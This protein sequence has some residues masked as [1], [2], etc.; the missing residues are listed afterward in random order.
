LFYLGELALAHTH[1]EQAVALYDRQQHNSYVARY[2][3]DPAVV[4]LSYAALALWLLGYPDRARERSSAALTLAQE[5]SH[6]YSQALALNFAATL[7][8]YR[9][10]GSIVQ[11]W[12]ET[13]IALSNEQGFL[14]RVAWGTLLHG[15]ALTEQGYGEQGL[16]QMR[17]GLAFWQAT[18]A[19]LVRPHCL[20]MLAE[21]YGKVG[22]AEEG[23]SVL[24][25][26]LAAVDKTGECAHEAELYRLKGELTLHRASIQNPQSA[27][28]HLQSEAE[29]CFQK[30]IEIARK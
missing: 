28:C 22:Q 12:A 5:L 9:R 4:C 15:W 23:L 11:E 1:L 20:A 3:Q 27:F 26:A 13:V 29:A 6:P 8:Q 7:H 14:F 25:E 21:T 30:A 2:G 18:G 10:E 24:T 19:E 17:Q 16:T